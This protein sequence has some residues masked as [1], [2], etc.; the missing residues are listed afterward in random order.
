MS[1]VTSITNGYV[2]PTG[3]IPAISGAVTDTNIGGSGVQLVQMRIG[4]SDGAFF[5]L[6]NTSWEYPPTSGQNFQFS[7][8]LI[9][10]TFP[11]YTWS[12]SVPVGVFTDGYQYNL[13]SQSRDFAGNLE[14]AYT[15]TTFIVDQSSPTATVTYPSPNGYVNQ[16][17]NVS[18]TVADAL[19]PPGNFPG[20]IAAVKVRISTNS[21][22]S[23]WTGSSWTATTNTWFNAT[24]SSNATAWWVLQSPWVT[25]VTYGAEA[26]AIDK[27]GNTQVAYSTVTFIADFTPPTSTI[28]VPNNGTIQTVLTTLSGQAS[29]TPPGQ[30]QTV[31]LSYQAHGSNYWNPATGHFDSS[32]PLYST[33]AINGNTWSISGSS[34][35][36]QFPTTVAGLTYDI[37]AQAVDAAGN[38]SAQPGSPTIPPVQS[39]YIEIVMKTPAPVTT[40]VS[41]PIG[42]PHYTPNSIVMQGGALNY[43]TTVQVQLLECGQDVT[44][45]TSNLY[46]NGSVWASTS[47]EHETY[48]GFIGVTYFDSVGMTWQMSLPVSTDWIGNEYY[49]ITTKGLNQTQGLSET[50]GPSATF[51]IDSSAPPGLTSPRI[52]AYIRIIFP[53]CRPQ[54]R[55]FASRR[56]ADRDLSCGAPERSL[57]PL[58]LAKPLRSRRL[59]PARPI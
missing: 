17:G 59:L 28:T 27:A 38:G 13:E 41:P 18:G 21:F 37:F 16:T 24:L 19:V 7:T 22:T 40:I 15:T 20:G 36:P 44:C 45:N 5:N 57:N 43:T 56:R 1:Q 46:W 4:R 49:Q 25:N 31:Q 26:Y 51:V 2:S 39:S 12:A 14:V 50:A 8:T 47:T 11:N 52:A 42:T 10:T 35:V 33:A 30:L 3:V 48:P 23:F 34:S 53:P 58:E 32:I 6:A 55:I 9:L 54:P 29:D